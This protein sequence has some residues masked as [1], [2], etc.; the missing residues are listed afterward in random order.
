MSG[1]SGGGGRDPQA[2]GIQGRLSCLESLA[3][4]GGKVFIVSDL[5]SDISLV[6]GTPELLSTDKIND[7]CC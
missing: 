4:R 2:E 1:C 5:S 7:C 3:P 6:S